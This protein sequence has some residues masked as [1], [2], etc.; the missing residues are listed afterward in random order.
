MGSEREGEPTARQADLAEGGSERSGH[1]VALLTVVGSLHREAQVDHRSPCGHFL[2]ESHNAAG[3]DAGDLCRPGGVLRLSVRFAEQVRL[4]GGPADAVAGEER[5]VGSILLDQRVGE[6]GH[7]GDVGARPDGKPP[8]RRL[9]CFIVADRPDVHERCA[10]GSGLRDPVA[11]VVGTL[12]AEKHL[13]VVEPEAAEAHEELAP[14]GDH[15]PG[16]LL[17]TGRV[18]AEPEDVGNDGGCRG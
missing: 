4:H 6:A 9:G 3:V 8:A 15:R 18:P 11:G 2:G 17:P 12:P 1:P 13:R 16:G 5:L 14:L 10:V 7:E